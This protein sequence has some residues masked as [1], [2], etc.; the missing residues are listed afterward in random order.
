MRVAVLGTG[1]VGRTLATAI[2]EAG[3]EVVIGTRDPGASLSTSTE[4]RTL[5]DTHKSTC[6]WTFDEAAVGADLAMLCVSGTSA[7]E[8]ATIAAPSLEGTVLIDLTNPLDFSGG[9]PPRLTVCNTDSLGEQ[10]QRAAPAARVVKAFNTMAVEV[11]V[12]P[13]RVAGG[14]HDLFVCGEDAAAKTEVARFARER[15]GWESIVDLGGIEAARGTEMY[16]A[17][18]TRA[19]AALGT[20]EFNIRLVR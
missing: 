14:E 1:G 4:L 6:V 15:F 3:D 10:V 16:L 11:M 12:A 18:W 7:V 13:G 20:R 9:F 17:L 8:V 5:L 2:A 19:L